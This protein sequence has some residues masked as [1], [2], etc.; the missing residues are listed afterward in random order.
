MINCFQQEC[1]IGCTI[2]GSI[3][4]LIDDSEISDE[5]RFK[6][7]KD[8]QHFFRHF[9]MI[10]PLGEHIAVINDHNELSIIE[11][12]TAN[13]VS[14]M[15][16]EN[17]VYMK[18]HPSAPIIVLGTKRGWI[19]FLCIIQQNRPKWIG[20]LHLSNYEISCGQFSQDGK[21]LIVFDTF[22]DWFLLKVFCEIYFSTLRYIFYEF[23][24]DCPR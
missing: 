14:T 9:T 21:I 23:R 18:C 6:I 4:K 8:Y 15:S 17:V 1:F 11:M 16:C 19:R 22:N 2:N 7:V 13:Y 20:E 3:I 5:R 24:L 10:K 12:A